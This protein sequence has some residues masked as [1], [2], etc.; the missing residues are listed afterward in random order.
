MAEELDE[1]LL[2]G[3]PDPEKISDKDKEKAKE[4][5]KIRNA[6]ANVYT[7]VRSRELNVAVSSFTFDHYIQEAI[8]RIRGSSVQI[9]NDTKQGRAIRNAA[10]KAIDVRPSQ[11]EQ[12]GEIDKEFQAMF[13]AAE[14]LAEK[15][16]EDPPS[17]ETSE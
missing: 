13:S 6:V 3:E 7:L 9:N 4:N 1:E 17:E 12:L 5:E 15:A 2:K 16:D 10:G 14:K 8:D 11:L